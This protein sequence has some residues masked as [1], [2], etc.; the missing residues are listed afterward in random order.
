MIIDANLLLYA[1][2]RTSR[3]HEPARAWLE[4]VLNGSTRAGL[5]WQSLTTFM[6]ISTSPRILARPLSCEVAMQQVHEWLAAPAA[7]VPVETD[8]HAEVFAHLVTTHRIVG[9]LIPDARLA[10]L[11][12]EH[13]VEIASADGD[14]ARFSEV[15]WRNP[16]AT[17]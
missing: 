4:E 5:P 13:G 7:W 16:L 6:R 2:D 1:R 9:D 11:A 8:R 15:R 12:L 17:P 3:F 10:A 14:F